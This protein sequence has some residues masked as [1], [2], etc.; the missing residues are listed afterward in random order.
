MPP[1]AKKAPV[2]VLKQIAQKPVEQHEEWLKLLRPDGPFIAL[3]VLVE[4]LPQ[5]LDTVPA[6]TVQRIR[7]AWAEVQ[8]DTDLLGPAW[9]QLILEELLGYRGQVLR[10]GAALPG[11]L[12]TST[13]GDVSGRIL[14]DAVLMGPGSGGLAERVLVYRRPWAERLDK[15]ESK[16]RQALTEQAA[17]LCRR[18]DVPV[19]LLTNGRQWALLHARPQEP[20]TIAVFDADLWLEEPLLLR[21]F[22]TL[23]KA[24]RAYQAPKT[25][26][27]KYTDS[28]AALF[29]RSAEAQ[30][31]VTDTLG[32]QV[33]AAVELLVGE[34]SRLDRENR[35]EILDAI[36]PR[37]VYRAALT[38]MMRLVFLLYAEEQRL[39][40]ID[41]ELYHDSYAVSALYD[42]LEIE[43]TKHGDEVG[44]RREAAW[45]RLLSIFAALH[46]GSRHPDL[47]I[48]AYGGSL[49]DP[50]RFSWLTRAKVTDRVVYQILDSLLTLRRKGKGAERLSYKGLDVEQIGHVYEGL[51]EYSCL[52]VTEP[53]LGLFGKF[54][55]EI[56]LVEL[57]T[58]QEAGTL[59][60]ELKERTGA[61]LK[62]IAKA[63][64][65]QPNLDQHAALHAACDND[66]AL[67]TRVAG[68]YGLLRMD[69][70]DQPTVFP[71]DAV[72]VTQVGDRR[73]TGTHYTPRRL[74]E[75]IVEH[76]LAPLCYAPGPAEGV[77]HDGVW[78][79]KSAREL[80]ELK[81]LDPAMGSGAFLV[82]ACRYVAER[83]V[84]AWERDG[85]PDDV[86]EYAGDADRDELLLDAR[87]LV[88]DRCLHGV[89]RDEMA[90]E[91]AKLSLWLVTLAKGRP[92]SFLDHA[93]RCGD[94]LVGTLSADQI[95]SFHLDPERGHLIN[96]RITGA[97]DELTGPLL[98]RAAELRREI[99]AMPVLDIRD[100]NTK[101]DKLH[102][103]EKLTGRLR[104]A[105]DAVVGAALSA[106][107]LEESEV[108]DVTGER[109]VGGNRAV[110]RSAT[111][112]AKE[113]VYDDRL[114]AVSEMVQKA[115]LGDEEAYAEARALVDGWLKGPREAPIRPLHWPL[116]FPELL[117]VEGGRSFD[118]VIGNPPFI[119]GQKL[120]GNL[121]T[122][123]REYL[124]DKIGKGVRGSA[125][126]CAYF[127]LRN[128]SL[129]PN[130]RT[131]IIATN[132][133]AQGDTRE[134]GLDQA[135]AQGWKVYRA[136]KS[137]PWPGAAALE[138]SLLWIGRATEREQ[139][140]LDDLAVRGITPSLD[141]QSRVSGN[142]YRLVANRG[143][144]RTSVERARQ[145]FRASA[146]AST[147]SDRA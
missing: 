86:A 78:H 97:I 48:P 35:G 11:D 127:L 118:A 70:R 27:G 144:A 102:E 47:R 38:V 100:A 43:R 130:R 136:V 54:E 8:G 99:E 94:S 111:A 6:E 5:G 73:A 56:K 63:L 19:A 13:V 49:F 131:G 41:D 139:Y 61:T 129:A 107:V 105:A 75:E 69:L 12:G 50:D 23:L 140:V 137:Q 42:L 143:Q 122:D 16:D 45:P 85:L 1:T 40:P 128:L 120:T 22:T 98:S 4:A 87:R 36:A 20:T 53:Y 123:Y 3:P 25:N 74:A 124:V 72:I 84:E 81:I 71:T 60:D 147:G 114:T 15:T 51:L 106:Q 10:H 58:W 76:T 125:D 104:L 133:I 89:D 66:E 141:A 46:G 110:F 93:L 29:A 39:L 79:A 82:S 117:G 55:P 90:V 68:F 113:E 146:R 91:L 44:D 7:Q 101:A 77:A 30:A 34:L 26:E 109:N 80:L 28:L 145:G 134:V 132:T 95:S 24:R 31:E 115:I 67:A 2:R 32:K 14:P 62:Q 59:E 17:E 121:G 52:K 103:A 116:D 9:Q 57:E 126:L 112:A 108:E 33:R 142:P 64:T 96:A 18:R 138:V 92:F 37:D 83:V 119:G 88:A 65:T 21:S 135:V